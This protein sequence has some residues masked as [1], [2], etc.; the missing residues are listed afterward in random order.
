MKFNFKNL[1]SILFFTVILSFSTQAEVKPKPKPKYE[2]SMFHLIFSML[3]E[4]IK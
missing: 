2:I 1:F 3:Q 4:I